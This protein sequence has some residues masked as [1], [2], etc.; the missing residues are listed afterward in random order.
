MGCS[1]LNQNHKLCR[2]D[3]S[4]FTANLPHTCIKCRFGGLAEGDTDAGMLA[5]EDSAWA[6]NGKWSKIQ[7][8][9]WLKLTQS[10]HWYA[11][12]SWRAAQS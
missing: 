1:N 2:M 7:D 12:H 5:G 8:F 10:P 6:E 3:G 9:D 11:E 4:S